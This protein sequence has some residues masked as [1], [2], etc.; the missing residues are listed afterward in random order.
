MSLK[1]ILS[2]DVFIN[3]N[4]MEQRVQIYLREPHTNRV[5][6]SLDKDGLA[7]SE[8]RESCEPIKPFIQMPIEFWDIICKELF[9][10]NEKKLQDELTLLKGEVNAKNEH[11]QNLNQIFDKTLNKINLQSPH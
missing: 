9:S 8:I 1:N 7:V 11:I 2:A 6:H 4:R 3:V 5:I 10:D